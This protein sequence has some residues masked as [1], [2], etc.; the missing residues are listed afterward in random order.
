MPP[1]KNVIIDSLLSPVQSNNP[2]TPHHNEGNAQE[3][4]AGESA[5]NPG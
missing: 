3:A 2:P 4:A 1:K 5:V